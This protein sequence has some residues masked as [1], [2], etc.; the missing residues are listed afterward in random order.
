[1]PEKGGLQLLP[2]TR[3][4]IEVK[5]PGENRLLFVSLA[6]IIL[7]ALSG[8]GLRL[9]NNTLNKKL[10]DL[11]EQIKAT[12]ERRNKEAEQKLIIFHKQLTLIAPLL[13]D[14]VR[15]SQGLATIANTLQSQIQFESFSAS[16]NERRLIFKAKT[17]SYST[18]AKQI[19]SFVHHDNISDVTLDSVTSRTDGTLQFNMTVSFEREKFLEM[20]ENTNQQAAQ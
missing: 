10:V 3:K 20:P 9:Y 2:E 19:A 1:M 4:S 8:I 13:K 6:V 16:L 14:H 5:I 12:E 11:D 17:N 18:I 15:W 7:V